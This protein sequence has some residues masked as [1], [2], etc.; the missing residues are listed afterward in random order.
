MAQL[1]TMAS[2]LQ[3][4]HGGLVSAVTTNTVA[5][6]G[7]AFILRSTDTFLIAG[8][9]FTLPPGVPHPCMTVQWLTPALMSTV[10][11]D[12]VLTESSVGLCLAPDQAPQGPVLISFTQPMVAGV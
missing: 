8:C 9:A 2:V 1:L 4:P 3:C 11:G 6:A 7:G 5:Q 10:M 12:N